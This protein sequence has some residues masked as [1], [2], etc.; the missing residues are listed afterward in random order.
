MRGLPELGRDKDAARTEYARVFR[1]RELPFGELSRDTGA[2]SLWREVNIGCQRAAEG[3]LGS[4]PGLR[5]SHSRALSCSPRSR[6]PSHRIPMTSSRRRFPRRTVRHECFYGSPRIARL[7]PGAARRPYGPRAAARREQDVPSPQC[8]VDGHRSWPTVKADL[9]CCPRTDRTRG[10]VRPASPARHHPWTSIPTTPQGGTWAPGWGAI[11]RPQ[12][13]AVPL[14]PG[15]R[16]RR[17][18]LSPAPD[19][20]RSDR[21]PRSP[22]RRHPAGAPRT[23]RRCCRP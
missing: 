18:A 2:N 8:V 1:E 11:P 3:S 14:R 9:P 4:R 5:P 15:A 21:V 13:G 19:R 22:H 7:R 12:P 20:Q 6:S 17:S 16:R 23:R 10:P